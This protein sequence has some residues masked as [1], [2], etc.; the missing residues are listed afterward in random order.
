MVEGGSRCRSRSWEVKEAVSIFDG[1]GPN[2]G[3]KGSMSHGVCKKILVWCESWSSGE[4]KITIILIIS[5]ETS[6]R[7][8]AMCVYQHIRGEVEMDDISFCGLYRWEAL[9]LSPFLFTWTIK[10]KIMLECTMI[11]MR[12][13]MKDSRLAWA[14]SGLERE[15]PNTWVSSVVRKN[16]TSEKLQNIWKIPLLVCTLQGTRS[17]TQGGDLCGEKV[18]IKSQNYRWEPWGGGLGKT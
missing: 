10:L 15:I 13:Y 6:L 11:F 7:H 18:Q 5:S 2:W 17:G 14:V 3:N 8:N 12:K 9:S 16:R 1:D 4:E